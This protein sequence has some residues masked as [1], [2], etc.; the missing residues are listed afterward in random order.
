MS[1]HLDDYQIEELTA[2]LDLLADWLA[3]ADDF[4]LTDLIGFAFRNSRDPHAAI[5]ALIADL[6]TYQRW[7][8]GPAS[9]NTPETPR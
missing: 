5:T 6:D 9:S 2:R 4:T 3:H 8:R 1:A 7:L